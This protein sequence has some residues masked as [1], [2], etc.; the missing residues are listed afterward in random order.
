[1]TENFTPGQLVRR[2]LQGIAPPRPLFLPIVFS[3]GARVENQALPAFLANPTKI[4][5]AQRQLRGA[6]RTDGYSC[7]FDSFLEVEALGATLQWGTA[8]KVPAVR[9]P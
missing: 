6:L 7:Y 4:C 3:S 9:W 2:L 5:S 8:D 1:M